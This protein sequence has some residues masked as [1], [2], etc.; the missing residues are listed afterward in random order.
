MSEPLRIGTIVNLCANCDH[1][2]F[3]P[4]QTGSK[5]N[6]WVFI[7]GR[8]ECPFCEM[9]RQMADQDELLDILIE[10]LFTRSKKD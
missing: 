6:G 4:E 1:L 10:A 9:N 3:A 5:T 7:Q 2:Y 8:L